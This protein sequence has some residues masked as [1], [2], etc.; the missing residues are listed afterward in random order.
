VIRIL[1]RAEL[2]VDGDGVAF[3]LARTKAEAM[4]VLA[5]EAMP[6]PAE[7]IEAVDHRVRFVVSFQS[8]YEKH[9]EGSEPVTP[10]WHA[11]DLVSQGVWNALGDPPPADEPEP[12]PVDDGPNCQKCGHPRFASVHHP[13]YNR[14]NKCQFVSAPELEPAPAPAAEVG[15]E[16]HTSE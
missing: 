1:W 15:P 10:H 2:D 12:E 11:I 4:M 5:E 8:C 6:T 3:V 7:R 14:P 9:D 16:R 13:D